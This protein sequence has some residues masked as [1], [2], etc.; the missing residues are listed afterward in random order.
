MKTPDWSDFRRLQHP[1][2]LLF[3]G[4]RFF[5]PRFTLISDIYIDLSLLWIAMASHDVY[6]I[7]TVRSHVRL[8][9]CSLATLCQ[10]LTATDIVP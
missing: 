8:G 4:R 7:S 9:P 2:R 1:F 5:F 6:A 10:L 3:C